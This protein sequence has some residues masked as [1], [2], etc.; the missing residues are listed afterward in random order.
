VVVKGTISGASISWGY[1]QDITP[2]LTPDFS[3]GGM[4][5][6]AVAL[7]GGTMY[8][9]FIR[10]GRGDPLHGFW[11]VIYSSPDGSTWSEHSQTPHLTVVLWSHLSL[12][13]KPDGQ[14][15]AAAIKKVLRRFS[16]S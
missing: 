9:G 5:D 15:L 16:C 6:P 7:A 8:A 12:A 13:A 14:M 11:T 10:E 4:S 3:A 2:S 1:P